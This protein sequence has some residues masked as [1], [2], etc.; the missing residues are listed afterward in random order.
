MY[1]PYG[2]DDPWLGAGV[3][4]LVSSV[5]DAVVV[6]YTRL[7]TR[8]VGVTRGGSVTVT[9]GEGTGAVAM[10]V[11]SGKLLPSYLDMFRYESPVEIGGRGDKPVA[12]GGYGAGGIATRT[13]AMESGSS[14]TT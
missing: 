5:T 10:S 14:R 6:G 7:W 2:C 1:P 13:K 12:K 11:G 3:G 9:V 8:L 4:V